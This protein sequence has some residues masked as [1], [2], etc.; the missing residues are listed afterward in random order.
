MR[1][2]CKLGQAVVLYGSDRL[3]SRQEER[4]ARCF[5]SGCYAIYGGGGCVV[6]SEETQEV[7]ESEEVWIWASASIVQTSTDVGFRCT[8]YPLKQCKM[9]ALISSGI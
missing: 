5:S 4:I 8:N 2:F 6:V 1:T 7:V 9:S 3:S